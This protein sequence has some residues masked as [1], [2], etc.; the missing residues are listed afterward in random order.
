[1]L[2]IQHAAGVYE[3]RVED[4]MQ[5]TT[6]K[7][8]CNLFNSSLAI[9][10]T[11]AMLASL[12]S[13][14]ASAT[15]ITYL[16]TGTATTQQGVYIGQGSAVSGFLTYDSGLVDQTSVDYWDLFTSSSPA[17]ANDPLNDTW[18][19]SITNGGI[20][21]SSADNRNQVGGDH[22][23][24]ALFSTTQDDSFIFR[25][26]RLIN[27][28]DEVRFALRDFS[29]NAI[30]PGFGG[31]PGVPWNSPLDPS[32]FTGYTD[33]RQGR[34]RAYDN[35][36]GVEIGYLEFTIDTM[37]LVPV[38]AAAWL[39]GSGMLGLGRIARRRKAA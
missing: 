31:L 3:L 11:I 35:V 24:L 32:Q 16:F 14:A 29:G 36:T 6:P 4:L 27:T 37:S 8:I 26:Q 9:T 12:F 30:V 20:V 7:S 2:R 13:V 23:D 22:H 21:R 17:G 28:D 34:I 19:I 15:A 38:P 33:S 10:V 1:V 39:F 5:T 18:E 25:A